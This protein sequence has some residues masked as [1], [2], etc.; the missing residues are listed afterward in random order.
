M[1]F[2]KFLAGL[3]FVLL[4]APALAA[5]LAAAGPELLTAKPF[6]VKVAG[7]VVTVDFTLTLSEIST[8]P[9]RIT[10]S[11]CSTEEVLYEGTLSE[12][13]Y[14]LSAPLKKI[15]GHGDL[16]VVL[17]T[18]VTNRSDKGNDSFLVYLKWQ[19]PM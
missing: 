18:R 11:C 19:G 4:V 13:V 17:K 1:R 5:P 15:S 12:G 9:V 3:V 10:A 14:R 16:K 7:N 6:A 8:Y 2:G